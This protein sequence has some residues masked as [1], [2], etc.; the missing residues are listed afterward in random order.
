MIKAIFFDFAG[1]LA[2]EG[3]KTGVKE[4]EKKHNIPDGQLYQA[5]HDFS[6]WKDFS[7]GKISEKEYWRLVRKHY[8][9]EL[10]INDVRAIIF[11]NFYPYKEQYLRTLKN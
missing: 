10:D 5:V 3:F 7:L 6:H 9:G 1:V 2:R 8:P 11:K 4:Y